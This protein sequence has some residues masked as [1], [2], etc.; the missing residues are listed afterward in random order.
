MERT[1]MELSK[2]FKETS[3]TLALAKSYD[4][5]DIT[6]RKTVSVKCNKARHVIKPVTCCS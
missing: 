6:S 1:A 5:D 2:H 3:Y 4:I